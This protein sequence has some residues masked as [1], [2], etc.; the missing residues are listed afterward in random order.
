LLTQIKEKT[1]TVR[2]E[3]AILVALITPGDD[4]HV[5]D[6]A[7]LHDLADTAG[8]KVVAKLVQRR[9]AVDPQCYIGKGK[10]QELARKVDDLDADVVI[11]DNDL[12]PGQIRNLEKAI[13]RKV[14]DRSELILDIFATRAQTAQARL[15]VELAQLQY[16]YPRLRRMWTHLE[17]IAGAG[18]GG[19]AGAV[20][21]IGTRGPGEKQLEV[22]RRLVRK[23]ID[24]LN[25]ELRDIDKRKLREVSS[26]GNQFTV[27]L[28]GYTNA[29]KSTLMN[30]LT[31]AG[32]YVQ[33][34]LFATLDTRT[35]RWRLGEGLDAMLSDTVGFIRNL[36]H[37][38]VASFRATLE[39][40]IHADLLI[41]VVDAS[42]PQA[43]RQIETVKTVL[44]EL[45]CS[46]KNTLIVFNKIDRLSDPSIVQILQRHVPEGVFISAVTGE[47]IED[48]THRVRW[49][50]LKPAI[51]LTLDVDFKAGKLINFLKR[52]ARIHETEYL[53]HRA[54]MALT[55]SSDW[56]GPLR[57]F[58]GEFELVHSSDDQ[59]TAMLNSR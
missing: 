48:L 43:E 39:E 6:L 58:N 12:S 7:E 8:A 10:V 23:R 35:R 20:G 9:P 25:R 27:C 45:G 32:V 33:D 46:E 42:N 30:A 55:L 15:Q 57:Q 34:K 24:Q 38:L 51:H 49:Y 50:Y 37:H 22:D 41:H 52:H 53:D 29:G 40:A 56:L 14:I 26:R 47:G 44:D 13:E 1:L 3:R 11:F 28:V 59:A 31:A 36:P 54:R 19:S 21:G 5:D 4:V 16:T 18:G 2:A 17:R